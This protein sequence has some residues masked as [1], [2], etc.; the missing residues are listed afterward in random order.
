MRNL[1]V[2]GGAGF[3]GAN[4]AL[5]W[6]GAHPDDRLV[7]LDAL[8]YAGN[9]ASLAPLDG[10][11]NFRFVHG[12]IGD[13]DLVRGLLGEERIDTIV[14][15]AAES[16]VDRSTLSSR[17]TSS[18]LI[19]CYKPRAKP[20]WMRKT[21]RRATGFITSPPTR[22]MAH[23]GLT[24]RPSPR[25]PRM[26]RTRRTPPVRRPQTTWC[27]RIRRPMGCRSA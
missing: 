24:T 17:P 18:A 22:C 8:T 13:T 1:L 10:A 21:R 6:A 16:H 23:W 15:F 7:V 3:I 14:H 5:Y 25:R 19:V 11:E 4:F 27:V 26:P 2:T 9:R 20:G 12:D